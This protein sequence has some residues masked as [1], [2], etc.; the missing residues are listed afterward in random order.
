MCFATLPKAIE[1]LRITI[2][3]LGVFCLL[4]GCLEAAEPQP[5]RRVLIL[6]EVGT[7]YPGVNL[8][9]Q[10]IRAALDDSPN[11]PEVYREYMDTL[12]FPDPADQQ[13]F[14]EFYIRKYQNRKP[15]VIITV[16]P[17]PLKFMVERRDEAFPGVPVIYCFPR[18]TPGSPTL[19]S[20]FTGVERDFASL[21]TIQVA[22]RL[23]PGTRH[24]IV[25]GGTS[26]LDTQIEA[27]VKEQLRPFE[28]NF[29]VSYLTTLSMPNL[30]DQLKH[31]PDHAIVLFTSLN[32]DAAG[33]KFISGG[34]GS[35]AVAAAA[36]AP[37]FVLAD[38]ILNHGEVGGK[39]SSLQ[40]QGRVA[41]GMALRVLKGERPQD[42]PRRKAETFY[43]FDWRALKRWGLN[44]K[45]LP[46]GSVV[47]NRPPD[48]W[49][50][51]RWFFVTGFFLLLAQTLLIL[52]LLVQRGNLRNAQKRFR[53]VF[54]YSAVGMALVSKDGHWIEVNKSLCEMLGYSE[55]ELLATNFQL[56]T[57]PDD[58]VADLSNARKV[59]T[60]EVP[61]YHM[62]KRYIHK[63]GHVVWV[64]LT[65]SA[66]P[67][68]SG[69]VSYGIAQVQDITVKKNVEAALGR[70]RE[71]L[72][73]LAGRLIT[74][75]EEERKR[76]ARDLHDDLSQRL[77]LLCID[78]DML[79]QS[80]AGSAETAQQLER[81]RRETDELVVD[82]RRLS[83]QEHH[84]QLDL[85]F[86]HGVV[87]FC[88]DF[89]KKYGI[90]MKLVHEGD[91][92]QIPETVSFTLF[93][94]L[95]EALNN[96][97][98]HSGA[99][100]VTVKL[101]VHGNRATL[102][103]TDEGRGFEIGRHRGLGLIS[104]RERLRLVEGT[105]RVNSY[106]QRGTDVEVVVPIPISAGALST[107]A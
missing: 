13:R 100:Q 64:T 102:R 7:S 67:D 36:N 59:F 63:Q 21:E 5:I 20:D 48:F 99:D 38:S 34:E 98:K 95:Q 16:G 27:V 83:H 50:Q 74:V 75:Q 53:S 35:G 58:L 19:P 39:V 47:L 29:D 30:L 31:L 43:M 84:P 71:E 51:Y 2:A 23:Q 89:S 93:R 88:E 101:S 69:K 49:Q 97:A 94:V 8:L 65:A 60:G 104:M 103:V 62:E 96:V 87:S 107:S 57:H 82:M 66:V 52:T 105:M 70:D 41:G 9:D 56:L 46:A 54:E 10:G 55:Q 42:V 24:I 90:T 6:Y 77:A 85:G 11:K 28:G 18:W 32:Q 33:R 4:P 17:F 1:I 45:D 22:L 61:F 3:A 40:E 92:E 76:I 91:L 14:R 15:D 106:P 26:F 68:A 80:L 73:S 78:L 25:V 81:M 79:R 37:V 86:Q 72:R 12:L 44:E